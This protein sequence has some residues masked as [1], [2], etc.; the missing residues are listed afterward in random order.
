MTPSVTPENYTTLTDVT[1]LEVKLNDQERR[2]VGRVLTERRALLIETTED[3]Y[4]ENA[5]PPRCQV[6]RCI[7]QEARGGS[8]R[9]PFPTHVSI[10]D[11]FRRRR[12]R[13][14]P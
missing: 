10:M 1:L 7:S 8:R 13:G 11:G 2:V 6:S 14:Y 4:S 5:I 9:S 3:K 12:R